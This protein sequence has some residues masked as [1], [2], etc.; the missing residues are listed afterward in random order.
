[1]NQ[2]R[3]NTGFGVSRLS[4]EIVAWQQLEGIRLNPFEFDVI[5]QLDGV[6][7]AHHSTAEETAPED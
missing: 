1:M 4:S 5:L 6:F 3:Q 2:M 7:A